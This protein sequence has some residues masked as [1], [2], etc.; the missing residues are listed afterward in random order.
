MTDIDYTKKIKKY[1]LDNRLKISSKFEQ[2][3]DNQDNRS[4]PNK[5][6]YYNF[7]FPIS[8]NEQYEN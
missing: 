1:I 8:I 5:N 2:Y 6:K 3:L 7:D 4:L